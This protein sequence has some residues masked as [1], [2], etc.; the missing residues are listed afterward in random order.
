MASWL[1][2]SGPS[3]SSGKVRALARDIVFLGNTLYSYSASLQEY[4]LMHGV[5]LRWTSIPSRRKNV[6]SFSSYR[7]RD[8]RWPDGPL[9]LYA[10]FKDLLY[11]LLSRY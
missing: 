10:G 5:T 4:N 3:G 6:P 2:R 1:V 11:F 9:G 8:K 7:T